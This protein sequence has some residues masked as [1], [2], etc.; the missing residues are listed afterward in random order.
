LFQSL[1]KHTVKLMNR[2]TMKKLSTLLFVG[3]ISLAFLTACKKD[4]S[5]T[6]EVPTITSISPET[7]PANTPVTITGTGFNSTVAN[8]TV[9]FNGVSAAITACGPTFINAV[10]PAGGSTG[11]VVVKTPGGKATGPIFTYLIPPVVTSINPTSGT[12]NTLVTIRGKNFGA[13]P[14]ANV[15]KFNGIAATVQTATT[16]TLTVLAP[17]GGTTGVVT[18]TT[19]DGTVAGPVFTYPA[20]PA[21]T[22]ISP[23]SGSAGTLVTIRGANFD[24]TPANSVVKFEGVVATVTSASATSLVVEVPAGGGT[25]IVTVT[26]GSGTATGP[27]F[28]YL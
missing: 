26:T 24:T 6:A 27:N 15:V 4:S 22:S 11:D 7:G 13:T 19:A 18:V 12:V 21:I 25:V 9:T 28:T 16:T 1:I 20:P 2:N 10:A 8:N 3:I 14:A 23:T 17:F 5:P